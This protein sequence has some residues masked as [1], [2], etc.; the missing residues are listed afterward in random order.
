MKINKLLAVCLTIGLFGTVAPTHILLAQEESA[1]EVS[2]DKKKLTDEE[3]MKFAISLKSGRNFNEKNNLTHKDIEQKYQSLIEAGQ[4]SQPLTREDVIEVFGEPG[5]E[6]SYGDSQFI[7]YLAID[8]ELAIEV[9]I[10]FYEDEGLYQITKDKRDIS[11]F[12]TLAITPAEALEL[13]KNKGV[14]YEDLL[15]KL[16]EPSQVG[17]FFESKDHEAIWISRSDSEDGVRYLAV[18][19]NEPKKE[20][21]SFYSDTSYATL[22]PADE[23]ED[24]DDSS[25]SS[26]SSN[27]SELMEE[28][29]E[30]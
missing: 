24:E 15:K 27:S 30:D 20:I 13:H 18:D 25:E 28:S 17:Y 14:S 7:H 16:G 19:Y 22:Y 5:F 6:N 29:S 12:D 26:E 1:S 4:G 23:F 2:A 11:L 9:S 8:E 10:Q 21:L 3:A